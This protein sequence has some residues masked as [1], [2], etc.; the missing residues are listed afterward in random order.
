MAETLYWIVQCSI[1]DCVTCSTRLNA[2]KMAFARIATQ[3]RFEQGFQTIH[4]GDTKKSFEIAFLTLVG[5]KQNV[6]FKEHEVKFSALSR[7]CWKNVPHKVL[8]SHFT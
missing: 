4:F 5:K 2:L 3:R 8:I 7:T 1:A 6:L